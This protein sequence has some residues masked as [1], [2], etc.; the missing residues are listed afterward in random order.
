MEGGAQSCTHGRQT[1][2]ASKVN[3]SIKQK[4]HQ[5]LQ[6]TQ[7]KKQQ[8]NL[9]FITGKANTEYDTNTTAQHPPAPP[10]M[11]I[12]MQKTMKRTHHQWQ[13][14]QSMKVDHSLPLYRPP[15]DHT[16]ITLLW[17][18]YQNVLLIMCTSVWPINPRRQMKYK[19]IKKTML[20]L[21]AWAK[22]NGEMCW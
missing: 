15:P 6:K 22:R 9:L 18:H 2:I 1:E 11:H 19:N 16:H 5:Q 10:H 12:Q 3:K 20:W 21:R 14:I 7:N 8:Q 17:Q 13:Q 4:D